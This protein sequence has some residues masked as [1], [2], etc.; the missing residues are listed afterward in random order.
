[1][2]FKQDLD[3]PIFVSEI[4]SS[5]KVEIMRKGNIKEDNEEH[6]E[7]LKHELKM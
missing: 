4:I 6:S 3:S 5:R 7:T 2:D 1:M